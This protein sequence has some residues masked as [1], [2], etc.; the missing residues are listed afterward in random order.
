M[1]NSFQVVT[2]KVRLSFEHVFKAQAVQEGQPA[3]FSGSF[4]IPKS[5]KATLQKIKA[6][7]DGA[8]AAGASLWGGKIPGNLKL[9][10]RDGDTERPD[11]PAYAN[12]YFVNANSTRK[13]PV[14]NRDRNEILDASEIYSG[15]YVRVCLN[16]FPFNKAGN[17]GVGAGLGAVQKWSDGDPL[18]SV[19]NPDEVFADDLPDDDDDF[20]D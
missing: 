19:T 15:C 3:K 9:P 11:D 8:K 4:I 18:G 10:L 5:D 17:K 16:F 1:A 2:G 6:A 7:V 13:P 12:A 14:V 20:L